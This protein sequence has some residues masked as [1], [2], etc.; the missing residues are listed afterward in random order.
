MSWTTAYV[1]SAADTINIGQHASNP[2]L[3]LRGPGLLRYS[4]SSFKDVFK[5]ASSGS[6]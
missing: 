5:L 4:D 6:L 2:I 1:D 3:K